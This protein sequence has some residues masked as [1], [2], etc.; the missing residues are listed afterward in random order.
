MNSGCLNGKIMNNLVFNDKI[1]S[2]GQY[3]HPDQWGGVIDAKGLVG[4]STYFQNVMKYA[5]ENGYQLPSNPFALKRYLMRL[6]NEGL[7]Q[8]L[9]LLYLI[10]GDG[11]INFRLMNLVNPGT[12]NG[13]AYGGLEWTNEGVKGNRVNGY[14]YT[15]M[16]LSR[17]DLHKYQLNDAFRGAFI[18]PADTSYAT[19]VIDF[20]LFNPIVS[21][22]NSMYQVQTNNRKINSERSDTLIY[23]NLANIHRRQFIGHVRNNPDSW[24]GLF[25]DGDRVNMANASSDWASSDVLY[26]L[27]YGEYNGGYASDF[28]IRSYMIGSSIDEED[29]DNLI[30]AF[31]DY[32]TEINLE[33]IA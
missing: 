14:I 2:Y 7:I 16:D 10:T 19:S 30:S 27:R 8:K 1:L 4:E 25:L 29:R 6:E 5:G 18:T 20:G 9:D 24:Y 15:G 28:T 33:P 23:P 32:L 11:D 17:V 3:G 21:R 26:L 12:Y 31:N 13:I 22:R